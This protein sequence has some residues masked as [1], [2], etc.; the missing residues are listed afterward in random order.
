MRRGVPSSY[1]GMEVVLRID[2]RSL[3]LL[4]AAGSLAASAALLTVFGGPTAA[5]P[6]YLLDTAAPSA[7]STDSTF[8]RLI[9][10]LSEPGG[11]FDTDNLIS[12]EAS[13]LHVIGQLRDLAVRGGA[14]I[15]VGP[16]QNFSYMAEIRPDIAFI[17]DIRRDN[18][19]EHL[20]FKALFELAPTRAAY[21]SL[22]FGRPAPD[23]PADAAI[24]EILAGIDRQASDDALY[25]AASDRVVRAVQ[26]IGVPLTDA[27]YS[28]IRR[29]HGTFFAAGPDLRFT[30]FGRPPR[31][32]Y[33]TFRQLLLETDREGRRASWM[34]SEASY[35]FVRTM[36]RENRVIPVVG[37]LAGSHALR[38][39]GSLLRERGVQVSALYASNV[40][41]YLM[42]DRILDRFAE[43]VSTLPVA[44]NSVIIRS[45]FGSVFGHPLSV[46]G[47]GS[48]QLLQT[49]PA[50]LTHHRAGAYATYGDLVYIDYVR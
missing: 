28:T 8:A 35:D 7:A 34:T 40:E 13:Y 18:L 2:R 33:P 43:N 3:L 21:L 19:L 37:N 47:Y 11:Y 48:T 42:Q 39:I 17:I 41:Y 9:A 36:Q 16:D 6:A 30:S 14:Y 49:I 24:D 25:A 27:D 45:V 22:L 10:R 1:N 44:A 4:I 50:F 31:P 26:A 5:E 20:L 15:G 23:G 46:P 29:F 38:E 32:F 12:N